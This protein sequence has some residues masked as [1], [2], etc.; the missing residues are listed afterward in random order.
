MQEHLV[1]SLG[2]SEPCDLVALVAG[3]PAATLSGFS[4]HTATRGS[5]AHPATPFIPA[6]QFDRAVPVI[7]QS[8]KTWRRTVLSLTGLGIFAV[9]MA[10]GSIGSM[11]L[12]RWSSGPSDVLP[13]WRFSRVID[14]GV[15]L[16]MGGRDV[17]LPVG[18]KLPN[19]DVVVSVF[20]SRNVVVLKSATVMVRSI[21]PVEEVAK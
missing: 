9:A 5:W 3:G 11:A 16:N 7:D 19:G 20:P 18:A 15:V 13:E 1:P 12:V 21:E 10:L 4:D 8:V 14:R 6:R 2:D 17:L